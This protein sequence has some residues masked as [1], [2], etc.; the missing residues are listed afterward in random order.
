MKAQRLAVT[1]AATLSFAAG[2][3]STQA[4]ADGRSEVTRSVV[5]QYPVDL[6]NGDAGAE[7]LY[8]RLQDA[9]RKACGQFDTKQLYGLKEWRRCYEAALADA[10][11]K[12][13]AG[14]L[15]AVRE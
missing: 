5:V 9:A 14:R 13:G 3:A 12:V 7:Q 4:A 11:K 1:F 8:S 10:V 2:L 6:L 15:A